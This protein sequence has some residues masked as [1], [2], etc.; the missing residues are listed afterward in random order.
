MKSKSSTIRFLYAA[1]DDCADTLYLAGVFVPDPYLSIIVGKRSYAVVSRLEYGRVR[2]ASRYD[3]VL[4][5]ETMQEEAG[6]IL[7]LEPKAVGP[8]EV[9]RYFAQRFAV[10]KIEVPAKFPAAYYADLHEAGYHVAIKPGAFFPARAKKTD[11][12]A[13]AIRQGNA[14]A[15]AGLRVAEQV[16][17]DARIDGKVLR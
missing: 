2:A 5:L 11:T 8:G 6:R 15:A 3:E 13:R 1:S 12:E 9:M 16:L 14:A 4:L 7:D 17:R 10:K